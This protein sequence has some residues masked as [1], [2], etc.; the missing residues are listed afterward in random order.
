MSLL[1]VL[2]PNLSPYLLTFLLSLLSWYVYTFKTSGSSANDGDNDKNKEEK[3]PIIKNNYTH[4]TLSRYSSGNPDGTIYLSVLGVVFDVT[5][6]ADFYG[7]GGPYELF[8]GSECSLSLSRMSLD[9]SLIG[10][11][12]TKPSDVDTAMEWMVK[13]RD[14]KGYDV[15]GY[16]RIPEKDVSMKTIKEGQ[17]KPP[18]SSSASE[19]FGSVPSIYVGCGPHIFDVSYGGVSMYT[20]PSPYSIFVNNDASRALAKMSLDVEVVE[21]GGVEGLE[22]KELDVL[23]DW[24]KTFRDKKGYPIVGSTGNEV[25]GC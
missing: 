21:D 9:P 18:P 3:E 6:G 10:K 20:P 5:P 22:G 7:K 17:I 8:S 14:Y 11:I 25:T 12:A 24:V 13:F 15:V 4:E 1:T 23:R 19:S 16:V 2:S